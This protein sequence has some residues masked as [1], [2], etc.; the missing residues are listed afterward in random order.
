VLIKI[1]YVGSDESNVTVNQVYTVLGLTQVGGD[2]AAIIINDLDEPRITKTISDVARWEL[3]SVD[4]VGSVH[5][6]P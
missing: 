2:A 5:L 1:K 6:F 4:Y 3:V